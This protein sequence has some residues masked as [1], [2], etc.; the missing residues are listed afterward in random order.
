M[1]CWKC[2]WCVSV[3]HSYVCLLLLKA[4]VEIK[5]A[6]SVG[7]PLGRLV[8]EFGTV[9]VNVHWIFFPL[10]FPFT[11]FTLSCRAK[12]KKR[13]SCQ[14]C[15]H[16]ANIHTPCKVWCNVGLSSWWEMVCDFLC[17]LIKALTVPF[18]FST[19]SSELT[20]VWVSEPLTRTVLK[21][22]TKLLLFAQM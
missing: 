18:L 7:A 10:T 17:I 1:D 5:I 14:G 2:R 12:T 4:P 6:A 16:G 21:N 3:C 19:S 11:E 13:M 22:W 9:A 20:S 8:A 15:V